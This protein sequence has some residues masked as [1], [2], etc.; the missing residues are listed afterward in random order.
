M[1]VSLWTLARKALPVLRYTLFCLLLLFGLDLLFVVLGSGISI[2]VAGHHFLSTTIEFPA[3]GFLVTGLLLLSISGQWREALLVLGALVV[4]GMTAELA[5]RVLDHPL[6]KAHIDYAVWYKPSDYY[7]HELVPGF[8]GFGPL[9][10][11][12]SINGY[13]FR[14]GDHQQEKTPGVLR[15]LGLGDSFM[16][17]WGVDADETFLKR[18]EVRL[19]GRINQ[20]VETIN[21]GVPGWGLNQYYLFLKRTGVQLSPDVVVVAYF[22]DDLNGPVQERLP[23]SSLYDGR[24]HFK[25]GFLHHS[26][27][28]NFVK[29]LSHII[30]EKNRPTRVAYLHDLDVRRTEWSRHVDY[31]MVEADRKE[32]QKQVDMLREHFLRLKALVSDIKAGLVVMYVPD[33]SQLHHL[34]SQLINRILSDLCGDISIPFVDMTPVF[35][36]SK[37]I[38]HYY[39]CPKDP[40]SNAFGH[41]EMAAALERLMCE[42]PELRIDCK[43]GVEMKDVNGVTGAFAVP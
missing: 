38:G 14:D 1:N 21:T 6:S 24:L 11:A 10:V 35:E 22:V 17:G 23:P 20:S 27:L 25:D 36:K 43:K 15:V 7:G 37:D 33:I 34:E 42:S 28:F 5:L 31:L 18:L 2:R 26:R 8:E 30:R 13:G 29:S 19:K 3:I 32:M 4:A 12:V 41:A 9:N 39:L 16:F 40:H